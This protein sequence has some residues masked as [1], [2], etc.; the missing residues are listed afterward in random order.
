MGNKKTSTKPKRKSQKSFPVFEVSDEQMEKLVAK[1]KMH[2]PKE[3]LLDQEFIAKALAEC[4]LEGDEAAFK[5]ILKAH[6]E[7][8][9]IT[10]ALKKSKLSQRT[11]FEALSPK[12]N[13]SLKTVFKI[14]KGLAA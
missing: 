13:P 5:E 1:T 7:A 4:L 9:N 3:N 12:G 10:I 11:F 8:M 14:M 6:Y 2:D